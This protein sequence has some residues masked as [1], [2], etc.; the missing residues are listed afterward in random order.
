MCTAM[1]DGCSQARHR[2][3]MADAGA[4][5]AAHQHCC[6]TAQLTVQDHAVPAARRRAALA[7]DVLPRPVR[8][9]EPPGEG[10]G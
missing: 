2:S 9:V 3:T 7:G 4:H 1:W 6:C 10:G 5:G 8:Q